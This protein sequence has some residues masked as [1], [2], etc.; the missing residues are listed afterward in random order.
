MRLFGW[1]PRSSLE[2]V[3]SGVA[4]CAG[5]IPHDYKIVKGRGIAIA[6][7]VWEIPYFPAELRQSDG[8][9]VDARFT[10]LKD[11]ARKALPTL[12]NRV[13]SALD[14]LHFQPFE[15]TQSLLECG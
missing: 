12:T 3:L 10:P 14:S 11:T 9:A 4:H 6:V 13:R 1:R 15:L 5:P 8:A 7:P 2:I